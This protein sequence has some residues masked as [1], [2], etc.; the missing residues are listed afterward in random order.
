M[1]TLHDTTSPPPI[2]FSFF[3]AKG[4]AY[5][6]PG[7]RPGFSPTTIRKALKGRPKTGNEHTIHVPYQLEDL[8]RPFRASSSGGTL[9]QGVAGVALGYDR[10]PLWGGSRMSGAGC[11]GLTV[12]GVAVSAIEETAMSRT[13]RPWHPTSWAD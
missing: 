4:V 1:T 13:P 2:V 12:F 7:Q 8:G 5:R 6:S 11:H 10:V 9:T 3:N